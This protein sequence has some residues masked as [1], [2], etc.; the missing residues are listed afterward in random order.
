[1]IQDFISIDIGFYI[2][3]AFIL[4]GDFNYID[5][6]PLLVDIQNSEPP[7]AKEGG[8]VREEAGREGD[9]GD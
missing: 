2:D 3:R 1:M 4:I 5:R 8:R 6:G 9:R 7:E